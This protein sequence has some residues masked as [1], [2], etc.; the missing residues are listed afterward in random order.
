MALGT[1]DSAPIVDKLAAADTLVT[2]E[3]VES[4]RP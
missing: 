2:L 4:G 3:W 1:A